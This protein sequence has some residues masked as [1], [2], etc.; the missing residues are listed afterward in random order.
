MV[1]A[2]ARGVTLA[3]FVVVLAMVSLGVVRS[4]AAPQ[5]PP[6]GAPPAPPPPP[7]RASARID[8]TGYWVSL[9]T[10]DWRFRMFT[11]PK[12]DY[13]SVPPMPLVA[14]RPTHGIP[15]KTRCPASNV[16]RTGPLRS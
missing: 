8:V 10:E 6:A 5:G 1:R 16:E 7:G 11:P 12:G 2:R 14:P 3:V 13:T 15:L 4:S 9:V